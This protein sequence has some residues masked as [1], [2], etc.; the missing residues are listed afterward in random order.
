L[1]ALAG[2]A[3]AK[4]IATQLLGQ[5]FGAVDNS[6]A[7]FDVDFRRISLAALAR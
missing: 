7:A 4:V 6:L 1:K 5:L 3:R 2:A